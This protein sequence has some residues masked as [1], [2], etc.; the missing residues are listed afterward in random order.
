MKWTDTLIVTVGDDQFEVYAEFEGDASYDPGDRL[1]PPSW[2][3]DCDC[4]AASIVLDDGSSC[5]VSDLLVEYK[6]PIQALID[7]YV[8]DPNQWPW[9]HR[10]QPERDWDEVRESEEER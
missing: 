4:V 5:A 3:F 6:T 7:D 10:D 2:D 9:T 8:S 1:T